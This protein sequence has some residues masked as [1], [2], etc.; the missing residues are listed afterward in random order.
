VAFAGAVAAFITGFLGSSTTLLLSLKYGKNE[1][2]DLDDCFE[3]CIAEKKA[4]RE[5]TQLF[6][7]YEEKQTLLFGWCSIG[8]VS[9][10]VLHTV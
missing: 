6:S 10:D 9:V 8:L 2:D 4:R 1:L 7:F 3:A 5:E